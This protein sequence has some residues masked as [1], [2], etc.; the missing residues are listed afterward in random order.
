M[1]CSS[2]DR[3]NI[4]DVTIYYYAGCKS[5]PQKVH[6]EP[7]LKMLKLII[8]EKDL[9]EESHGVMLRLY[10]YADLSRSFWFTF[11]MLLLLYVFHVRTSTMV[12]FCL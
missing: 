5:G 6:K 7:N 10:L 3:V 2:Q 11:F 12:F 4:L 9:R 1:P 8:R